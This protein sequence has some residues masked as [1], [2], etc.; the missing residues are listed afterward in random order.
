MQIV[1]SSVP[2]CIPARPSVL[3]IQHCLKAIEINLSRRRQGPSEDVRNQDNYNIEREKSEESHRPLHFP[4]WSNFQSLV[5]NLALLYFLSSSFKG[6]DCPVSCL[7]PFQS[8]VTARIITLDVK[9]RLLLKGEELTMRT[10]LN[11]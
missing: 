6:S 3:T 9:F 11:M 5:S 7:F 8:L 1:Q 4:L 2:E 10:K